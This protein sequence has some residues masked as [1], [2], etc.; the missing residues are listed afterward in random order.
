[1]EKNEAITNLKKKN[2]SF[3]KENIKIAKLC[4]QMMDVNPELRPSLGYIHSVIT[5]EM[6]EINAILKPV[7]INGSKAKK[8]TSNSSL[9]FCL[10]NSNNICLEFKFKLVIEKNFRN[11][12][13][14]NKINELKNPRLL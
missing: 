6:N 10:S 3:F 1:M 13:H 12:K 5:Q 9:S 11:S 2:V 14:K 4:S 8:H 7:Q